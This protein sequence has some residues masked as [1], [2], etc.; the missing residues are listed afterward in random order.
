MNINLFKEMKSKGVSQLQL[1]KTLNISRKSINNKLSGKN[2]FTQNEMFLTKN[3]FFPDLTLE[4]LF[5][6]E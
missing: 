3:V 2:E 5:A 1:A 4:Y 6:K